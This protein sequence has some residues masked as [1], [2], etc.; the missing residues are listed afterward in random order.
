MQPHLCILPDPNTAE[1]TSF[2]LGHSSNDTNMCRPEYT[3]ADV[4]K[5]FISLIDTN[6]VTIPQGFKAGSPFKKVE[7]ANLNLPNIMALMTDTNTYRLAALPCCI[8]IPFGATDT[9]KGTVTEAHLDILDTTITGGFYW[10][11]CILKWN[12]TIHN[13]AIA[14]AVSLGKHFP[15]LFKE[16]QWATTAHMTCGVLTDEQEEDEDAIRVL[17]KLSTRIQMI[18]DSHKVPTISPPVDHLTI[19]IGENL[20]SLEAYTIPKKVDEPLNER[21]RHRSLLAHCGYDRAT[22]TIVL[23]KHSDAA[24]WAY[25][26]ADK[27]SINEGIANIFIN[28]AEELE[29]ALDFQQREVELPSC[30]PLVHAQFGHS[31]FETSPMQSLDLTG[32]TKKSFRWCYLI[33]DS[34]QLAEE[35]ESSDNDRDAEILLGEHTENLSKIKTSI[36]TSTN[37]LSPHL[38]RVYLA[39]ICSILGATFQCDLT[40]KDTTTPLMYVIA[41]G[42][43]IQLSSASM[44]RYFKM[45]GRSHTELVL[46]IVQMVDQLSLLCTHPLRQLKNLHLMS[47]GRH[48]D[49]NTEKLEEAMVMYEDAI[50]T[51]KKVATATGTVPGC[52]LAQ[53]HASKKVKE[54]HAKEN[55]RQT[56]HSSVAVTN[57]PGKKPRDST[58]PLPSSLED[59]DGTLIWSG[60][61]LM[62]V[63]DEKDPK[64]RICAPRHRKG[65]ICPRGTACS[66]IHETDV[67]KWPATTF[68]RWAKLVNETDQLAWNPELVSPTQLKSKYVKSPS[69]INATTATPKK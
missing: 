48:A 6:V 7:L 28:I 42:F 32:E 49:I 41:R 58:A 3:T 4:T 18:R 21:L 8:P 29:D 23:P 50:D 47:S 65:A 9:C 16:Q 38:T 25:Y 33:A 35:R 37:V 45:S 43:A 69:H 34:K 1:E 19:A 36:K 68:E 51:L 46:W 55:K 17:E 27:T 52:T 61:G 14:E 20:P 22:K 11:T 30:D 59:R 5:N 44:R 60:D 66:F 56:P 67:G 39:N 15:K 63:V 40:L 53:N 26:S 2:L 10:T 64:L 62:P 13:E 12:K 31:K 54:S 24:Q 57:R